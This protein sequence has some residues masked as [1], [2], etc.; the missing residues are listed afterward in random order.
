MLK[1]R[2]LRVAHQSL[3]F[4]FFMGFVAIPMSVP[5]FFLNVIL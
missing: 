3:L 1:I 2:S 4:M 5:A